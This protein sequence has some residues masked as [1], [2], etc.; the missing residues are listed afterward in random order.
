MVLGDRVGVFDMAGFW[1]KLKPYGQLGGGGCS[2]DLRIS[3]SEEDAEG[4]RSGEK[5]I[6]SGWRGVGGA[7]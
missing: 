7:L 6:S 2:K 4:R 3:T 1:E 5:G